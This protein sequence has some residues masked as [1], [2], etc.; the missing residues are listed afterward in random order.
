MGKNC[1]ERV[2]VL[3]PE[4]DEGIVSSLMKHHKSHDQCPLI[5]LGHVG[6]KAAVG[7]AGKELAWAFMFSDGSNE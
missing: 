1:I 2:G 7:F 4:R 5:S 6:T 3:S